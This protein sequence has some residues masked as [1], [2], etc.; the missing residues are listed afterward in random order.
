MNKLLFVLTI[1]LSST[2]FGMDLCDEG[3]PDLTNY[4][5]DYWAGPAGGPNG[6]RCKEGFF[7]SSVLYSNPRN[8]RGCWKE[9]EY[10][11][12]ADHCSGNRVY[13]Q[14]FEC[15]SSTNTAIRSSPRKITVRTRRT[16]V[17]CHLPKC[18]DDA[19]K[20]ELME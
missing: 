14:E 11:L 3:S 20:F 1:V 16:G 18:D 8:I 10:F 13:D 19:G 2:A 6:H 9:K 5:D 12:G 4:V 15:V 17:G 7:V